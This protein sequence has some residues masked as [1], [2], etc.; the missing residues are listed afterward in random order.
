[1][2][3]L[4]SPQ[5]GSFGLP[6][7]A[8]DNVVGEAL[9]LLDA[10][11]PCLLNGRRVDERVSPAVIRSDEPET[12]LVVEK[13]YGADWHIEFLLFWISDAEIPSAI[14]SD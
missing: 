1:L 9:V 3:V 8:L 6:A 13:F 5:I 11:H 2:L 7:L 14:R 10:V 12:L 4:D